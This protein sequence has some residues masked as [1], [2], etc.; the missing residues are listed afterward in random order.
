MYMSVNGDDWNSV[1]VLLTADN[2]EGPYEYVGPVVYSGFS[3]LFAHAICE[4]KI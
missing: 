1:I 3:L 2:I 4:P